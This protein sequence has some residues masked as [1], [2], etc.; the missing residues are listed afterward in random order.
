MDTNGKEE[1]LVRYPYF[2][3]CKVSSFLRW[4]V[5]VCVCVCVCIDSQYWCV[6]ERCPA[7]AAAGLPLGLH[8][9]PGGRREGEAVPG[10]LRQSG[11]EEEIAVQETAGGDLTG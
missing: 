10:A 3:G 2:R 1:N 6:V 8:G 11:G 7:T 4:F 5:C 9:S